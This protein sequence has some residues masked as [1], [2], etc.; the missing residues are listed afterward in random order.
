MLI[1][2]QYYFIL[3]F[4]RE[5]QPIGYTQ[6]QHTHMYTYIYIYRECFKKLVHVI[7]E[8]LQDRST[9]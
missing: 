2:A 7:T 8:A 3:G 1:S 4:S 6:R 9:D 5:A